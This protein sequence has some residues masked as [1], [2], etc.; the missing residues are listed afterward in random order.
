M[1]RAMVGTVLYASL[2]KI[3]PEE[4]EDIL[5]KGDRCLAGP[6]VPPQGLYMT[7]IWYKGA[8]AKLFQDVNM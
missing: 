7:G 5:N 1:A 2:G 3:R 8:A 6:T 4:I